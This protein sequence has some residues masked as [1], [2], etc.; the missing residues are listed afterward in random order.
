MIGAPSLDNR[1]VSSANLALTIFRQSKRSCD[2]HH[3]K[4]SD[5]PV[6]RPPEAA[7]PISGC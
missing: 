7:R 4:P 3:D 5:L 1:A 6:D 2:C